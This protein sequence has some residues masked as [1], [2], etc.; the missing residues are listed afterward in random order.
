MCEGTTHLLFCMKEPEAH[1]N[2]FLAIAES[3][4]YGWFSRTWDCKVSPLLHLLEIVV[5]LPSL[6]IAWLVIILTPVYM[7]LVSKSMEFGEAQ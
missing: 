3:E 5:P 1:R 2:A 7:T 6:S 4:A